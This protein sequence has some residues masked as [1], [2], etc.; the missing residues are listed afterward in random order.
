MQNE[1]KKWKNW[2]IFSNNL[3]SMN[4][5]FSFSFETIE[6]KN[7]EHSMIDKHSWHEGL[8]R[9]WWRLFDQARKYG[10]SMDI[11]NKNLF[12]FLALYQMLT[13]KKKNI[14]FTWN[15]WFL[16]LSLIFFIKN[17]TISMPRWWWWWRRRIDGTSELTMTVVPALHFKPILC[18]I[19][20]YL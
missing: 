16:F 11:S 8:S 9:T 10:K 14:R 15:N 7:N 12:Q 5:K 4:N 3:L 13:R 2:L 17:K 18:S 1:S 6:E 19:G 20:L